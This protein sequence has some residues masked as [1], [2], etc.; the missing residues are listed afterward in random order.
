MPG[1][2]GDIEKLGEERRQIAIVSYA[3]LLFIIRGGGSP[4]SASRY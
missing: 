3:K 4:V 2:Q 1:E